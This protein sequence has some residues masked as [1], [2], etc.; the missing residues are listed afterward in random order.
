LVAALQV[1]LAHAAWPG[2]IKFAL[3]NAIA[4]PILF[5]SYHYL[6]RSTIIG[7]ML[8]G[9]SYPF[10][11]WPFAGAAGARIS[12]APTTPDGQDPSG[13]SLDARCHRPNGAQVPL[14]TD[15]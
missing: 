15:S 2:L 14:R 4:F 3:I 13:G 10:V 12:A 9:Q 11:V 8:N 6:V 7:R 1:G 5:L